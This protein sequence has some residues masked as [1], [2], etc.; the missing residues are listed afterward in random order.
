MKSY[1]FSFLF[2][3]SILF[4]SN[5][6]QAEN[7]KFNK[8]AIVLNKVISLLNV[9]NQ[10]EIALI[11]VENQSD[12]S[13]QETKTMLEAEKFIVTVYQSSKITTI[14]ENIVM[15]SSLSLFDSTTKIFDSKIIISDDINDIRSNM[16]GISIQTM[17]GSPRVFIS[18]I[19][20]QNKEIT[21]DTR[22]LRASTILSSK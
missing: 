18:N 1:F 8:K 21:V 11:Q 2:I 6:A 3:T 20:F 16:A 14:K 5:S 7:L 19:Y 4:T 9:K 12:E 10:N 22:L 15:V 17:N 13:I